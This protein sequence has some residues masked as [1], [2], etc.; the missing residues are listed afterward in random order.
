MRTKTGFPELSPDAAALDV[1]SRP[2]PRRIER[3]GPGLQGDHRPGEG[4]EGHPDGPRHQEPR[5]QHL[6]HRHGRHRPDDDDQAAA[7]PARE[8]R[9]DARRHPLRQQLQVPRRARPHHAAGRPGQGLRRGDDQAHRDAEDERPPAPEEPL[10]HR[11]ARRPHRI[12]AE[13]AEGASSRPSR[14]RWPSRAFPSS[15]SRW[16]CSAAP[17]SSPSSR[18]S[19]SPSPRSKAWSRRR[20]SPRRRWIPSGRST[21]S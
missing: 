14:R 6:H 20:R 4:P 3:G 15:R 1:L 2:R 8:G 12:P 19:P 18:A 9:Q 16:A 21:R 10:L 13:E 11:K 17:T 5:L 7:R